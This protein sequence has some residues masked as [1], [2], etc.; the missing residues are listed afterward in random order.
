MKRLNIE[1]GEEKQMDVSD[2]FDSVKIGVKVIFV[3]AGE[4][5]RENKRSTRCLTW[6]GES[7]KFVNNSV[8]A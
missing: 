8:C 1:M 4:G 2:G 6:C 5:Q 3:L 7:G